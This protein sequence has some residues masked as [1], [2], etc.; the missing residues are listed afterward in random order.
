MKWL[1]DRQ[2]GGKSTRRLLSKEIIIS[3]GL[4]CFVLFYE[5]K[6]STLHSA[7][8]LRVIFLVFFFFFLSVLMLIV[9]PSVSYWIGLKTSF[10]NQF[11]GNES[12]ALVT[13][14]LFYQPSRCI[15]IFL[16]MAF[17]PVPLTIPVKEIRNI[18]ELRVSHSGFPVPISLLEKTWGSH[19]HGNSHFRFSRSAINQ[20]YVLLKFPSTFLVSITRAKHNDFTQNN[21]IFLLSNSRNSHWAQNPCHGPC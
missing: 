21:I 8:R 7:E 6:Q 12:S 20:D 15:T 13:K 10:P 4:F 19:G 11:G 14:L 3:L 5:K 17:P 2:W 9:F 18:W 1:R 16:Q